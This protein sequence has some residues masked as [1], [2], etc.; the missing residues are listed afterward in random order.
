MVV[1][2]SSKPS[3]GLAECLETT[4]GLNCLKITFLLLIMLL[5]LM[6]FTCISNV[7][8][9]VFS[10]LTRKDERKWAVVDPRR[11]LFFLDFFGEKQLQ[12]SLSGRKNDLDVSQIFANSRYENMLNILWI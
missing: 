1:I 2:V 11:L 3:C 8:L 12:N 5:K 10:V 6:H 7:S 4:N 9:Y